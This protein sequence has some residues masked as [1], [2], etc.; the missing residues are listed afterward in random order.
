MINRIMSNKWVFVSHSNR[1]FDTVRMVRNALEEWNFRPLLFFLKCLDQENEVSDLIK[2]E[3]ECRTR[4]LLCESE[5]TRDRNG[6]V[7]KEVAYIQSLDRQYDVINLSESVEEIYNALNCFRRAST[8]YISHSD[9]ENELAT[10]LA[11]RLVKYD[12]DVI[13]EQINDSEDRI[14]DAIETGV[15]IPIISKDF[16]ISRFDEILTAREA[17]ISRNMRNGSSGKRTPS[18]ISIT[19]YDWY[20]KAEDENTKTME[21]LWDDLCVDV[22]GYPLEKQ[23]DIAI[24]FILKSMFSWGTLYAFA[25]NF[26]TDPDVIDLKEA[27]FLFG[28]FSESERDY[29]SSKQL[30]SGFLGTLARCYEFGGMYFSQDLKKA[31]QYYEDELHMRIPRVYRGQYNLVLKNIA[32]NIIR[33]HNKIWA[34]EHPD[35]SEVPDYSCIRYRSVQRYILHSILKKG[36]LVL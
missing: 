12:F 35:N 23:C 33:V 21:E 34:R 15:F 36:P 11:K 13:F 22:S 7:Q 31:L 30:C 2:R 9:S 1:D 10:M 16:S 5:H 20:E 29:T 17:Q 18:I 14:K 4:F 32:D 24:S 6:W 3:I 19:T 28:L 8:I 26:E 25:R 27:S